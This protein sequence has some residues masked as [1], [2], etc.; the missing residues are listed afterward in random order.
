MPLF[1]PSPKGLTPIE[2]TNFT[3]E[4]ELQSLIE[5]NL[6][7]IFNCRFVATEFSTG[8]LHAGR[9]DSLALSEE[10]NPVI[11]E[12]K[13]VESSEL[14]NQSLFY[15]H[16]ISDH[17]GDFEMAVQKALGKN[18]T[19]DWSGVRVICIAPNYKRYDL[20]AVQVMGA[21]IELWK[22]RLFK[23][24][25][26]YLEEVFQASANPVDV[27]ASGKNPI[28]VEAGRKA[29][30]ARATGVYTI[31]EHLEGKSEAIQA[32]PI[33]PASYS[34]FAA[35]NLTGQSANN[36]QEFFGNVD[37]TSILDTYSD[38]YA[39]STI[40]GI[41]GG[42]LISWIGGNT[43]SNTSSNFGVSF[44]D[45]PDPSIV[46][47][48]WKDAVTGATIGNLAPT[49]QKWIIRNTINGPLPPID[50]PTNFSDF[51]V[52]LQRRINEV[53]GDLGFSD[54]FRSGPLW[55]AAQLIDP[56]FVELAPHH[57]LPYEFPLIAIGGWAVMMYDIQ[58]SSG[59][60]IM[61]FLNAAQQ[62]PVPEPAPW[63]LL[64]LF[65]GLMLSKQWWKQV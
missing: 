16:W 19:V 7:P 34:S 31:E 14:I 26:L 48:T 22:Y 21:N 13:K 57:E 56:T 60:L 58:D 11:I 43:P 24:G 54:L 37:P 2:Q 59:Q 38:G 55:N 25:S 17:K 50:V 6:G 3:L 28:M 63:T 4:K 51:S 62:S 52:Y 18:V 53:N 23:N 9:I 5:K 20:H 46:T 29:A 41:D 65:L 30:L 61:T 42:T 47:Y 10:N 33:T 15:L 64:L 45:N 44:R 12:Y 39:R 1:E 27:D 36:F 8:A 49:N 40:I 32:A 35:W